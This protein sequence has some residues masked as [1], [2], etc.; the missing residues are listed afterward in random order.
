MEEMT[1]PQPRAGSNSPL[2][3]EW[4]AIEQIVDSEI[5][6][7]ISWYQEHK[8]T[9]RRLYV[10]TSAATVV[11]GACIPLLA[12]LD[13][14]GSRIL[15]AIVGVMIS[16]L[17]GLNITF[18][19]NQNWQVFSLAQTQLEYQLA[20]W[21]LAESKYRAMESAEAGLMAAREHVSTLLEEAHA[22]RKTETE[23]FFRALA[24]ASGDEGGQ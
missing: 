5:I 7:L 13:F 6:G 8:R 10:A 16:V 3:S 19:L 23:E 12:I 2:N 14:S 17:T 11:L 4:D 18:R 24:S 20:K 1:S 21:R 9:R 22:I 15:T